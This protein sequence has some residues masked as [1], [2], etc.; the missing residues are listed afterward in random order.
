MENSD[1]VQLILPPSPAYEK[2]A[3]TTIAHLG[4]RSGFSLKEI[5]DLRLVM[6]ETTNLFLSTR[7]WEN[8]LHLNYQFS[9]RKMQVTVASQ[10]TIPLEMEKGTFEAFQTLILPLVNDLVINKEKAWVVF[11]ITPEDGKTN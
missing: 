10:T 7:Q 11:E 5:E 6:R 3:Q 1:Q 8:P 9:Q 4:I 2:V